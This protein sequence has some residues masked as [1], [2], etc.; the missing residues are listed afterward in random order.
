[1]YDKND[2]FKNIEP[3]VVKF[4]IDLNPSPSIHV[5]FSGLSLPLWCFSTLVNLY[6]EVSVALRV[7]LVNFLLRQTMSCVCFRYFQVFVQTLPI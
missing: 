2:A 4:T 6:F 5:L 1:M 7:V 3:K